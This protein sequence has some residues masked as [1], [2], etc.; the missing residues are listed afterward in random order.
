MDLEITTQACG[1]LPVLRLA[2]RLNNA[3][4]QPLQEYVSG[5]ATPGIW[6][7]S[8]LTFL[9]SAGLRVLLAHEQR[10]RKA[11]E[12]A[13]VL[14]GMQPAVQEVFAITGLSALWRQAASVSEAA[15][16]VQGVVAPRVAERRALLPGRWADCLDLGSPSAGILQWQDAS[17]T[18]ASLADLPLAFGRGGLG[19]RREVAAAR[20][21]YFLSL[22]GLLGLAYADGETDTLDVGEPARRYLRLEHAT[23][24]SGDPALALTLQDSFTTG[25][26]ATAVAAVTGKGWQGLLA[27][28]PED[29]KGSSVSVL[30]AGPAGINAPGILSL[31]LPGLDMAT[32]PA[33]AS[34]Q[35]ALEGV[36]SHA[37]DAISLSD[38]RTLPPGTRVWV[39][40]VDLPA[41]AKVHTLDTQVP[42]QAGLYRDETELIVRSLYADCH[43]VRLAPLTGGFS[44][45]TWQVESFDAQGRRLLPTVLKVGPP[46]M[47][48]R[49][50][51]AHERYVGPFV[52]NN[53]SIG[54][55]RAAHG[56]AVGLRYNFVGVAGDASKLKTLQRRS[57]DGDDAG[58]QTLY[59]TLAEQTLRPWYGQA[60]QESRPLYADHTPLRLFPAL[61]QLA[62]EVL[63]ELMDAATLPCPALGRDLPNPWRF[64]AEQFP[65][66][67]AH[68]IPC[69]VAITHGDLNLNNVL[70][71]ERDNLYVIDFSETRERSVGSDFARLEP[72]FLIERESFAEQAQ[73]AAWL[74]GMQ[75]LYGSAGPWHDV[76][77]EL[78]GIPAAHRDFIAQLRQHAADYLGKDCAEEA[79][80]LPVLEW[81]L[82]IIF[83]GNR[84]LRLRRASTYVAALI[85]ERLLRQGSG[86]PA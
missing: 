52:L 18:A 86:R 61:P 62:R 11:G 1:D 19:V 65:Q 84:P 69:K 60:R 36:R 53:A 16:L 63:G 7:L 43:R 56:E 28:A 34:L 85:V 24:F 51:D 13:T 39:W 55:G 68:S 54:L 35:T 14:V 78:P 76:P 82:P 49:E 23:S 17:W 21:A 38:D 59:R 6:D 58:V 20:P 33:L 80:L 15:R 67:A 40:S 64:L 5:P 3:S 29:S 73:E 2:G 50:H 31:S 70:V 71:D 9:A 12:P 8:A 81:T 47:M 41:D 26:L 30:L 42:E 44:A 66:R 74:R 57:L 10:R 22:G 77:P 83:Y 46:A 27:I 72:V 79:Y 4:S 32:L 37:G 48:D 75:A 45:T 25:D